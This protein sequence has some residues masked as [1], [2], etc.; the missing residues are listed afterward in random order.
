VLDL[1]FI[2][3][4][5]S[6]F[7]YDFPVLDTNKVVKFVKPISNKKILVIRLEGCAELYALNNS[8]TYVTDNKEKYDKFLNT[9]NHE[10]FGS[11]DSAILFNDWRNI[12]KL[13]ENRKFDVCIMNP[14]YDKTLHL[15]ILSKIMNH[16]DKVVNI[17]PIGWLLDMTAIMQ[18]K[19]T[20]YQKYENIISKH[21]VSLDVL[22]SD[23]TSRVFEAAFFQNLGIY[24]IDKNCKSNLYSEIIFMN[25]LKSTSIFNKT[26]KKIYNGEIDN[27]Y[28][29]IKISTIHGH[30][31][32]K[33]DFDIVTPRYDLVKRLK[34][35]NMSE[36]E[37]INWHNSCSTK[38]M[39]YCNYLTRNGQH[40][41]AH[42]LPFMK[43]YSH[44]WTDKTFY[45]Y[46]ELT[47]S[48]I[49]IIE[50]FGKLYT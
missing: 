36:Q 12:D 33:D 11:D 47:D 21:I 48:E 10:K 2:G 44:K 9:V 42:L 17:S 34:P 3:K 38:C 45:D 50:R 25:S 18:L 1:K 40:V 26:I 7:N 14:P 20:T 24:N 37:F 30:F 23:E 16:C 35:D 29:H 4:V 6:P 5:G 28:Q 22:T 41:A 46:F 39:K 43:D 32:S 8:V 31:G 49:D 13:M 19:K 27:L 15:Q